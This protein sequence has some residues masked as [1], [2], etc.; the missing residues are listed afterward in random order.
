M[1]EETKACETKGVKY[2]SFRIGLDG[3]AVVTSSK[4]Q[5]LESLNFDQM[6]EIWKQGGATT[7]NQ[8]DS[9]FPN[10]KL[11]IFAPDTESG[12][13]DFFTE[14]VLGDPKETGLKP[15]TDYTASSD[16]NTLVQGIEGEANSWG[17]FGFAYYQ[18]NKAGLKDLKVAESR[19]APP[20]PRPR[21]RSCRVSTRCRGP[22]SSTSRKTPSRTPRSVS[23]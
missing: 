18:N 12:T 5:F 16:D 3:L 10:D 19:V 2:Q 8:V 9:K 4:N 15:R 14:K 21:R 1:A 7:W 6:A 22:C 23:S 11:A 13:Y 17:Y 20:S